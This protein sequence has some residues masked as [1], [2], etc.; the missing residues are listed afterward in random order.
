[1][2]LQPVFCYLTALLLSYIQAPLMMPD[3]VIAGKAL[4]VVISKPNLSPNVS[5]AHQPAVSSQGALKTNVLYHWA[6]T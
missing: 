5:E 6:H 3:V 1:M 2:P 4:A